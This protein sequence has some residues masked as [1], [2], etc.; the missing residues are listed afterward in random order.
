MDR[1]NGHHAQRVE[2]H[3]QGIGPSPWTAG[4]GLRNERRARFTLMLDQIVTVGRVVRLMNHDP[5]DANMEW[6]TDEVAKL[7]RFTD[8]DALRRD[9]SSVC[10]S[11]SGD[12]SV[13]TESIPRIS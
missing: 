13:T 10:G 6:L 3:G 11:L 8:E 2:D 4:K 1:L 5:S 12:N 7:R 9:G